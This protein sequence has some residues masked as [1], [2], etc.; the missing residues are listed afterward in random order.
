MSDQVV[1]QR[2]LTKEDVEFQWTAA[3]QK[4]RIKLKN[5]MQKK[6]QSSASTTETDRP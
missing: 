3:H 1:S 4:Y 2:E 6:R 5:I